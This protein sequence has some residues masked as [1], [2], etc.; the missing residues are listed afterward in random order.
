MSER[1]GRSY[2]PG[3]TIRY[4][5]VDS[6]FGSGSSWTLT[7]KLNTNDVYVMH[8][9]SGEV[10]HCSFHHSGVSQYTLTNVALR[11]NPNDFSRHLLATK[12]RNLVAPHLYHAHQVIV[13]H[14]ELSKTY[15]EKK[16]TRNFIE[17]PIHSDF[18][19]VYLN[20]YLTDGP[21]PQVRIDQAL[22]V[23]DMKLGGGG[24][25]LLI[26]QPVLLEKSVHLSFQGLIETVKKSLEDEGI[27]NQETR[28][29]LMLT[30]DQQMGTKVEAEVKLF[31][32]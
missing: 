27:R 3:S 22:L 4:K 18:D 14:S 29:V 28:F 30:D 17:I 16:R 25:A 20:L 19:A 12:D 2:P 23:A 21:F 26:A 13:A 10:I 8:R 9:E 6:Q 32:D 15:V 1:L 11:E 7:T 31:T 5:V 24:S